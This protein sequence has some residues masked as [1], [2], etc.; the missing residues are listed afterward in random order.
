MQNLKKSYLP[1]ETPRYNNN[2]RYLDKHL[3][4]LFKIPIPLFSS[5]TFQAKFNNC[6]LLLTLLNS[7]NKKI[8]FSNSLLLYL[9]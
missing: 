6:I 8:V 2:N 7:F 5:M 9:K 3:N 1:R 4:L